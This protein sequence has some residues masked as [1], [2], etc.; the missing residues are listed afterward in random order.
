MNAMKLGL[1]AALICTGALAQTAPGTGTGTTTG[2]APGTTMGAAP[3]TTMGTTGGLGTTGRA[4]PGTT[5]GAAPGTTMGAAPG[6]TMGTTGGIG[7]TGGVGTTGRAVPGT[8]TNTPAQLSPSNNSSTTP[9]AVTT[10]NANNKTAGAPVKGRNSFTMGE[11]RRRLEKGGFTQVTGLKKDN[12]GIWRGKAMRGG[13]SVD[14]Y[15][16]YQGNVGAAS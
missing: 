4:V 12:D 13:T 1:A 14:V 2:A 15:C 8:T 16:D 3:G 11:A 6:T 7:T 5:M 10:S 9:P